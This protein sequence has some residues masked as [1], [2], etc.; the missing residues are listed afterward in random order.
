MLNGTAGRI[1]LPTYLLELN[2]VDGLWG[3]IKRTALNNHFFVDLSSLEG[4]IHATFRALNRNTRSPLDML[5][6]L[7]T[8]SARS[9]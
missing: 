9:A 6:N 4:A 1:W 3:H 8:E 5:L 7:N 2:Y